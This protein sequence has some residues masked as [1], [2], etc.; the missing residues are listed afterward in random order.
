MTGSEPDFGDLA[1]PPPPPPAGARCWRH[2][3]REV[4]TECAECHRPVCGECAPMK[5][6]GHVFCR[7]CLAGSRLVDAE[8]R[9]LGAPADAAPAS[10]PEAPGAGAGAEKP[11]GGAAVLAFLLMVLAVAVLLAAWIFWRREG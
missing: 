3:D 11:G 2:P 9:I 10:A 5:G 7:D 6:G 1:A 8:P 4:T